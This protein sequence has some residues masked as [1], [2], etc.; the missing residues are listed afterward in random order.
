MYNDLFFFFFF[1][2]RN[3]QQSCFLHFT[4]SFCFDFQEKYGPKGQ[5][6]TLNAAAAKPV[7]DGKQR[8]VVDINV[9]LSER[10]PWFCRYILYVIHFLA[11]TVVTSDIQI[12]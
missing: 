3:I 2:E 11:S 1:W 7:K 4:G 8:P 10:P 5:G 9:G 6:K 12:T